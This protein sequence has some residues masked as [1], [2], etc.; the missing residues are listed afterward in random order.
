MSSRRS[1]NSSNV[2]S[3]R[4]HDDEQSQVRARGYGL[5]LLV[6]LDTLAK[7]DDWLQNLH[8]AVIAV[9]RIRDCLWRYVVHRAFKFRTIAIDQRQVLLP[10]TAQEKASGPTQK[11]GRAQSTEHRAQGVS[12]PNQRGPLRA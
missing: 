3:R 5:E 6:I 2:S 4:V 11:K 8:L 10:Q 7:H 1:R 9:A 12:L